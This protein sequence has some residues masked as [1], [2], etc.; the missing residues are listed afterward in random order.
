MQPGGRLNVGDPVR[1]YVTTDRG[2]PNAHTTVALDQAVISAVGYQDA[3]LASTAG[4][5]DSTGQRPPGKLGWVELLVDDGHAADFVQ[6][7]A[8]GDPDVAVL[9]ALESSATAGGGQ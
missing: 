7:L 4:S 6:T 1:V 9:P 3:A 5:S 2:K 8:S